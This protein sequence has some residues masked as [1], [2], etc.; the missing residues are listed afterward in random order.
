M[1]CSFA[2]EAGALVSKRRPEPEADWRIGPLSFL[3]AGLIRALAATVRLRFHDQQ[4]IRELESAQ[5]PFILA[6]WHRHLVLLRYAYRGNRMYVLVIQSWDGE[7][8]ARTLERLGIGTIRGSS[9]RRGAVAL[10]EAL[11]CARA[12]S[13]LAFTPDGPR[14]P[15]RAVQPG[16]VLAGAMTGHPVIPVAIA[17]SSSWLL[18]SWDRMLVPRPGSRVEV[19]YGESLRIRREEAIVETS[20]RLGEALSRVEERAEAIAAG[21]T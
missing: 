16:V 5:Q 10:R 8:T 3:L 20:L 13:D 15:L 2:T 11:R 21:S 6:F 12:G 1:N 19:V 4:P 7:L 14:G 17:A 18:R 9:S